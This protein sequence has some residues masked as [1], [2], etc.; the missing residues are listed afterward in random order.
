M[1]T[2]ESAISITLVFLVLCAL[3]IMP[4]SICSQALNDANSSIED[5][6]T[7]DG[8]IT[9]EQLNTFLTGISENYRIIYGTIVEE[10][11]NEE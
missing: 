4:I 7:E 5:V 10:V 2:V 11:S 8:F 9:P 1:S 6:L 3:I